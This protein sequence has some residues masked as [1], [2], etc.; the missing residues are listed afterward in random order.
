MAAVVL[1]P[2]SK[3]GQKNLTIGPNSCTQFKVNKWSVFSIYDTTLTDQSGLFL[4]SGN[5]IETIKESRAVSLGWITLSFSS[6]AQHEGIITVTNNKDFA[7]NFYY[8]VFA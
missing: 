6:T 8:H 3:V 5:N 4:M 7:C 2:L 1:G